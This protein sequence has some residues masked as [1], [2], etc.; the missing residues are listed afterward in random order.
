MTKAVAY[1]R[2]STDEQ[3]LGPE[4]QA[5]SLAHWAKAHGITVVG[6]FRDL[7]VSGGKPIDKRPGLLAA[8]AALREHGATILW[9]YDR[10]RLARDVK[11]ALTITEIVREDGARV[12]T[13]SDSPSSMPAVDDPDFMLNQ[14]VRDLFSAH[15]RAKIRFR[16]KAALA[17]LKSKGRVYGRLPYGFRRACGH[18][19]HGKSDLRTAKCGTL[20]VDEGERDT[21]ERIRALRSEGRGFTRIATRLN[22][23]GILSKRGGRWYASS[24]KSVLDTAAA[25]A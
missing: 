18:E 10:S 22:S 11:V 23:L 9:V 7:G 8:V 5:A 15:E 21:L 1:I 14:G 12:L 13:S 2:A 19:S 4:V 6:T 24:V 3:H 25:A 17:I 20:V 16:T